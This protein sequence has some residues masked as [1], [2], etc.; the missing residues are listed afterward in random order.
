MR[1][2][3]ELKTFFGLLRPAHNRCF[4]AHTVR[5]TTSDTALYSYIV[6]VLTALTIHISKVEKLSVGIQR[7]SQRAFLPSRSS[8]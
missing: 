8:C 7:I 1:E 2:R 6:T 3:G 5:S 4:F